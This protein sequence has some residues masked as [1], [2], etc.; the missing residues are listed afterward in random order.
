MKTDDRN[1][2]AHTC[3]VQKKRYIDKTQNKIIE[4]N[5]LIAKRIL[6]KQSNLSFASLERDFATHKYL[7]NLILKSK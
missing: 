3:T 4:E 2:F 1:K 6:E 7:S 5:H